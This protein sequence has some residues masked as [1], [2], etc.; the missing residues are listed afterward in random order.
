M[1]KHLSW[2]APLSA[3][4]LL[5]LPGPRTAATAGLEFKTIPP[6]EAAA[7]ADFVVIDVREPF[8][9]AE[10]LGAIEGARNIP[11]GKILA[12]VGLEDRLD[13]NAP[14]LMVCRTGARSSQAAA[15]AI[16]MGFSNV[17]TL[18]GGMIAWNESGQRVVKVK[19]E[20]KKPALQLNMTGI[21]CA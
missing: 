14:I 2:L 21:P 6:N 15:K 7:R 4:A 13:K 1:R 17:Y 5:W 12:G 9:L 20:A 11:L 10:E 8:E 3:L 16:A 19:A 18:Q